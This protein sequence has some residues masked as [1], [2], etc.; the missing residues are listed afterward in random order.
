MWL[1]RWRGSEDIICTKSGHTDGTFPISLLLQGRCLSVWNVLF[2]S[3]QSSCF[4]LELAFSCSCLPPSQPLPPNPTICLSVCL[5]LSL[6]LCLP[7][8]P[9]LYSFPYYFR[10][11]GSWAETWNGDKMTKSK[12]A[13]YLAAGDACKA[14]FWPTSDFKERTFERIESSRERRLTLFK[15]D[16]QQRQQQQQSLL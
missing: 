3:A 11:G 5:S 13:E 7:V 16:Q 14:I 6:S 4:I 9:S 15:I 8:C 12:E 1:Q 10:V 2:V